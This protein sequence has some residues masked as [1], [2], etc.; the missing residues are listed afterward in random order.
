M[1]RTA[2]P[3]VSTDVDEMVELLLRE[4]LA[5]D[6]TENRSSH[7]EHLVRAVRIQPDSA[8]SPIWSFS[9]NISQ[10]G[11]GLIT[12]ELVVDGI[13]ATLA[14][15]TLEG[16]MRRVLAQCKWSSPYG[17]NWYFSGWQF[18]SIR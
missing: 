16:T 2:G 14:I 3:S 11:I 8:A 15:E 9:R 10:T 1:L 17:K 7:R 5:Y 13:T 18:L 12:Q 6:R 4:E